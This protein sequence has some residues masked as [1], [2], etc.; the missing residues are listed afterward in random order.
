MGDRFEV[1][2]SAVVKLAE[3]QEALRF[4]PGEHTA[5]TKAEQEALEYL[6]KTEP[7]M[8]KRSRKGA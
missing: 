5:S 3:D 6:T 4:D 7:P 1:F 8:A 2:E